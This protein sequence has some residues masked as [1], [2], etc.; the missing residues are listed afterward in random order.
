M[1]EH[2]CHSRK[3][4]VSKSVS[5]GVVELPSAFFEE[6][7]IEPGHH[8]VIEK[9]GKQLKARSHLS[10]MLKGTEVGVS[11]R[12][13]MLLGLKNGEVVCVGD[14]TTLGDRL[15]DEV[16]DVVD[17]LEDRADR[18]R[19]YITEDVGHLVEETVEEVLD[20][21]I[22]SRG[23]VEEKDYI[24]VEPDLSHI[25]EEREEKEA[26][27]AEKVKIWTPDPDGDGTVPIFK[28]E[29]DDEDQDQ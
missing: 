3:V 6:A 13:S 24:E 11:P 28:P 8:V 19:D 10:E 26:D 2:D 9:G 7:G 21:V 18:V 16:E 4:Y 15:L 1:D 20:R 14:R 17:V 25:G 23:H 12:M 22:E 5:R 27:P 29:Q